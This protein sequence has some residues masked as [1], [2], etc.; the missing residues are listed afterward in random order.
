[1][2]INIVNL[3]HHHHIS[4]KFYELREEDELN[5]QAS[6]PEKCRS[7]LDT[8]KK[9]LRLAKSDDYSLEQKR[10]LQSCAY[11]Y[12]RWMEKNKLVN[13]DNQEDF[14]QTSAESL[15]LLM[16]KTPN[17]ATQINLLANEIQDNTPWYRFIRANYIHHAVHG[18]QLTIPDDFIGKICINGNWHEFKGLRTV[19][20]KTGYSFLEGINL[21]F[22]TDKNYRLDGYYYGGNRGILP[23][24]SVEEKEMKDFFSRPP[25]G[26]FWLSVYA[27]TKDPMQVQ[28][29]RSHS[30]LGLEDEKGNFFYAGQYGLQKNIDISDI[31]IP[32]GDK[33]MGV[34][35]PDR[36][37]SIPL[38]HHHITEARIEI[39]KEEY[40]KLKDSIL[41][42][43]EEGVEGSLIKGNCTDYV[44]KKLRLIGIQAKTTMSAQEFLMRLSLQV[45]PEKISRKVIQWGKSLPN[46][47][48]KVAHFNPIFYPIAILSSVIITMMSGKLNSDLSVL[49]AVIRP[50]KVRV[51]QPIAL[52]ESLKQLEEEQKK[53]SILHSKVAGEGEVGKKTQSATEKLGFTTKK[54]EKLLARSKAHITQHKV[55]PLPIL[56]CKAIYDAISHKLSN[57]WGNKDEMDRNTM[58]LYL[59]TM[60][61]LKFITPYQFYNFR[62]SIYDKKEFKNQVMDVLKS[63]HERKMVDRRSF[64]HLRDQLNKGKINETI[65]YLIAVASLNGINNKGHYATIQTLTTPKVQIE[66]NHYLRQYQ[67]QYKFSVAGVKAIQAFVSRVNCYEWAQNIKDAGSSKEISE[68][69]KTRDEVA[70]IRAVRFYFKKRLKDETLT[71]TERQIITEMMQSIEYPK[72]ESA[73]VSLSHDLQ[74]QARIHEVVQQLTSLRTTINDHKED[75]SDESLED[76]KRMHQ[77][78]GVFL[79]SHIGYTGS[80]TYMS[81]MIGQLRSEWEA[82]D[83]ILNNQVIPKSGSVDFWPDLGFQ[84]IKPA[85]AVEV[86]NSP[87][88]G[89]EKRKKV[90]FAYCSW[91]NGHKSVTHA[92]SSAIGKNYRVSTCDVPDEILIER[93]PLFQALGPQHSITTLYNTLVAGNY[94]GAINLLKQMGSSPTPQEEIEMQKALIRRKLLQENPDVVVVTY[95]R[96]SD[97]LLE[98]AKELGIPFVQVYTDMISHVGEHV[99]KALNQEDHYKHQRV[100]CP[101]PIEEM[102]QCVEDAG[103]DSSQ[104]KYMGFPVRKEFLKKHDIPTLKEKYQVKENQKVVLC[105]NGG[106]GGNTPWPALIAKAKKGAL[107]NI[108][109]I[110]VCGN[111]KEFYDEVRKLKA[112]EPTIEIEARGYTQA[113]E[114]AEISAIADV[115]ISKPGGATLAEN[116]LMKNY[117]LLDTRFSQSL[118]WEMDAAEALQ[119]HGLATALNSEKK[120]IEALNTALSSSVPDVADFHVFDG[121]VEETFIGEMQEMIKT[122]SEDPDM[123]RK[124]EKAQQAPASYPLMNLQNANSKNFEQNL[125]ALLHLNEMINPREII[126][127]LE[128]SVSEAAEKGKYLR[129]NFS[130]SAFEVYSELQLKDLEYAVDVI[131]REIKA[132]NEVRQE[133]LREI[134]EL[135]KTA[136][137]ADE[138]ATAPMLARLK[139]IDLN[140]VSKFLRDQNEQA[141]SFEAIKD[142]FLTEEAKKEVQSW[143]NLK[144]SRSRRSPD[145]YNN[146]WMISEKDLLDVFMHHPEELEFVKALSLHRKASTFNHQFE[147]KDHHL[148]ILVDG[149]KKPVNNLINHFKQVNGR[150]VSTEDGHEYTYT[151]DL[152]FSKIGDGQ[153]PIKWRDEIPLFKRKERK[154]KDYRLE[155]M[156]VTGQENHG[157][158]RLKDPEGNVYSVGTFWDPDYRLRS[159]QRFDSLPGYVRGAGDLQEF[160]G[161][162]EHWKRTKIRLDKEKFEAL[163]QK[164]IEQQKKGVNYNLINSNCVS[165]V[166]KMLREVG[167]KYQIAQRPLF[168]YCAP[169]ALRKFF[170][171]HQAAMAI[172]EIVT[173]PLALLQNALLSL[174]G[175]WNK[176]DLDGTEEVGFSKAYDFFSWKKG[177]VDHPEQLRLL[178]EVIEEDNLL[179]DKSIIPFA[180]F[181]ETEKTGSVGRCALSGIS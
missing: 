94:W 138:K 9:I 158:L 105:M 28:F 141:D 51:S 21:L 129:F 63:L 43:K 135:V 96:H 120:F 108:K 118:Q 66:I 48:K 32:F 155:I 57:W 59:H 93:D 16:G 85:A 73:F 168:V 126:P 177:I 77:N 152:G 112:I 84:E 171:R 44:G 145:K 169:R 45:F 11:D 115:T 124:R 24:S 58:L 75:F 56:V 29:G 60:M 173:Y 139:N 144:T 3:I 156:S 99:K 18:Q 83:D 37:S 181:L 25:S 2:S 128:S 20:T 5:V 167:M 68:A 19:E 55:L 54:E 133:T 116:I 13:E 61:N 71:L 49:N 82:I 100:L 65:Q 53:Y 111:N 52:E 166:G 39:T 110:V 180:R 103:I 122:A 42:D 174:L 130:T 97:L 114:M 30:Y 107:V 150:I 17:D 70:F 26:K 149:E 38:A 127:S 132:G 117:L 22:K 176:R 76:L 74:T 123:E 136:Q 46:W 109:L 78:L 143:I 160:L 14:Y 113:E 106:C 47:V 95:E 40:E 163:K 50:W 101:Y 159:I 81:V 7:P 41:K 31:L 102:K 34:E 27:S 67:N 4:K 79:D 36:Y 87:S 1:M 12:L 148:M 86:G 80:A 8:A 165:F 125:A 69:I 154:I 178:Q 140:R 104:V 64:I 134:T 91:G 179:K 33:K 6:S 35:T 157:W 72:G 151:Y 142:L 146:E 161:Q 15:I 153:H 147:V 175:M 170:I 137:K 62:E 162:E 121:K 119:K 92:L 172:A 98:V 88:D 164:I 131:V 23:G 10:I 90:F 89:S